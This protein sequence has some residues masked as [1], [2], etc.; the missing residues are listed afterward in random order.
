MKANFKILLLCL[1]LA[2]VLSACSE[3]P[4]IAA[5]VAKR[6]DVAPYMGANDGFM[7]KGWTPGNQ[8]SWTE[9]IN[10]R[11]QNQNEYSRVK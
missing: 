5:K 2:T 10:N 3:P 7:T 4:E 11:N 9:A 1:S 8:A 6:P